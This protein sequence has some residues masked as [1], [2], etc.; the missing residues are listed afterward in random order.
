MT[1]ILQNPIHPFI[2][3]LFFIFFL[4]VNNIEEIIPTA[5]IFPIGV[6]ISI[7]GGVLILG[8]VLRKNHKKIAIF[9]SIVV[10]LF[11]TYGHVF[12]LFDSLDLGIDFRH[13][14][15][16][17]VYG[18]IFFVSL[19]LLKSKINSK[20]FTPVLNAASF[21]LLFSVVI[22]IPYSGF[23]DNTE[24]QFSDEASLVFTNEYRPDIYY[25]ILD[26]YAGR[27][28][29][30]NYFEFDNSDFIA[31]LE[32]N[33]F[34]VMSDS[35][36]NYVQTSY[37]APSA[38]DMQ[39][40]QESTKYS[41]PRDINLVVDNSYQKNN[42][43]KFL[44][45]N[46]YKTIY[47]YGGI[48]EEIEVADENMCAENVI[49]DFHTMLS[50]T[51]ML[52]VYQKYQFVNDINQIRFCSFDA[53]EQI[54]RKYD[55]PVFVF[56]H[57]KLPHDPFTLSSTGQTLTPEKIDL[58]MGSAGN[59]AGYIQQLEFSNKKITE[60]IPKILDDTAPPIIIIQSDHGVRFDLDSISYN[61]D[62]YSVA[63]EQIIFRS[64]NNFSA[65][66]FPDETYDA[67]YDEITPVNTFRML[68]N[69]LFNTE[70]EILDDRMYLEYYD[71]KGIQRFNDVTNIVS[72]P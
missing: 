28:T 19:F 6:S 5:L 1:T 25:I 32:S 16:L 40:V 45:Q 49:T 67:I 15:L 22:N 3:A 38:M 46:G 4:Y 12:L 47:I 68:F 52:W 23:S 54:E 11:F 35:R 30:K 57:I 61:L 48:L 71:D 72:L 69:K 17:I 50:Q 63:D 62:E 66:Y 26:E 37:A 65:F 31:Y 34:Y 24:I 33:G 42:V 13:R 39:Y 29:L 2:F 21:A 60:L 36:S 27:E 59:K 44:N 10:L 8:F 14:Y 64:F 43:M 55:E 20:T 18:V 53:L 9:V 41:N 56:A 7:I 58:G 51:T 70:L